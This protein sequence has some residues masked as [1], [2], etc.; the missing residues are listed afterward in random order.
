MKP[1]I[2]CFN[3]KR[4]YPQRRLYCPSCGQIGTSKL[5]KYFSF[6]AQS[7]SII[8]NKEIWAPKVKLL[9]DPFE[10]YFH[11]ND[12]NIDDIPI[13]QKSIESAKDAIKEYG[14]ICLSEINNDILMWSH[15]ADRHTG[16]CI[17]FERSDKNDLGKW[18]KC[19]PVNYAEEVPS[20]SYQQITDSAAFAKIVSTKAQNWK[21]EKEWRLISYEANTSIPLPAEITSVIFGCK[22]DDTRRRTIENILGRDMLYYEAIQLKDRFSLEIKPILGDRPISAL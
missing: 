19:L 6:N 15:Y 16:F 20:F 13:D 5:Y 21:Y 11:L 7:L 10:F 17:E 1:A 2:E 22:M 12:K 8:I 3:C 4:V 18:D 9:N 14:V